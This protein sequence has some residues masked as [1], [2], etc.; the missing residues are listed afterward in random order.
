M[1]SNWLHQNIT[2]LQFGVHV[3]DQHTR[4]RTF[5]WFCW[6]VR[7]V[8][9]CAKRCSVNRKCPRS[10]VSATP[11]RAYIENNVTNRHATSSSQRCVYIRK[12]RE[13]HLRS[14][15]EGGRFWTSG[16]TFHQRVQLPAVT[17]CSAAI[18]PTPPP[19]PP[20]GLSAAASL[21]VALLPSDGVSLSCRQNLHQS[22]V[23]S[24]WSFHCFRHVLVFTPRMY[25]RHF[26]KSMV[27][28]DHLD[29]NFTSGHMLNNVIWR[30]ILTALCSLA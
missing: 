14:H 18:G 5:I 17:S 22:P 10:L 3:T 12:L 30:E 27:H 25:H 1:S 15:E 8:R 2:W 20:R 11:T 7:D 24:Y 19:L 9:R 21:S 6:T 23:C 28:T 4:K 16:E 13:T 26:Y 29:V